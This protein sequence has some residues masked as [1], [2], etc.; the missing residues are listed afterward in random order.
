MECEITDLLLYMELVRILVKA[1]GSLIFYATVCVLLIQKIF[2]MF[3]IISG[4]WWPGDIYPL[5][6]SIAT[7]AISTSI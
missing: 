4:S 6:L 2:L 1:K 3:F 5:K 7:R